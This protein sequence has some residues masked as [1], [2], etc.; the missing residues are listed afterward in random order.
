MA[1]TKNLICISCPRGC[2]L[3]ATKD[4]DQITIL[5]NFC[6]RGIDYGTNELTHPMRKVTSTVRIEGAL[7][8]RLPII[9]DREV[10]RELVFEIMEKLNDI[11]VHSPINIG[12][13]IIPNVLNTNANIVATRSM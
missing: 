10:P 8:D 6:K 3:T 7:H 9:T 13:I 12:D 11:T 4:G 5:G 2:H 1:I